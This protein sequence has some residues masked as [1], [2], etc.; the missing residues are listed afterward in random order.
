MAKCIRFKRTAGGLRCAEFSGGFGALLGG[1][2]GTLD[3]VLAPGTGASVAL[4]TAA[5]LK[6]F[7]KPA[8][9]WNRRAGLVAIGASLLASVL[10]GLLRGLGSGIASG[11]TGAG[12][13]GAVE[14][15]QLAQKYQVNKAVAAQVP[16][17]AGTGPTKP[18]GTTEGLGA[19]RIRELSG[20]SG[21]QGFVPSI[22]TSPVD[23][24]RGVASLVN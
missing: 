18:A 5:L 19:I 15:V 6:A 10:L 14:L 4:T 23:A 24:M 9:F 7:A 17:E 21:P 13:G 16:A 22:G 3:A 8:G 2:G 12:V 20:Y 11:L 1:G